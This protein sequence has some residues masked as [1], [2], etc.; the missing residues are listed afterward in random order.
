MPKI[1]C[2]LEHASNEI[3]GVKFDM[4]E[5]VGRVADVKD[6]AMA[7]IF[8]SI[9]GY[10]LLEEKQAEPV[11]AAKPAPKPAA[12][13]APTSKKAAAAQ[14]VEPEAPAVPAQEP[15]ATAEQEPAG[16]D[17]QDVDQPGDAKDDNFF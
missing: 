12:V 2:T 11:A 17:A 14:P 7:E 10:A 9:D 13:K 3:N 16:E 8:L 5:G 4:V 15:E 6:P 1:V